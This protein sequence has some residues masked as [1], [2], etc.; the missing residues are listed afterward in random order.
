MKQGKTTEIPGIYSTDAPKTWIVRARGPLKTE[1]RK[2]VHGTMGDAVKALEQMR[3]ELAEPQ[4]AIVMLTPLTLGDCAPRWFK[5]LQARRR[6]IKPAFFDTRT[7]HLERF[8]LPYFGAM[9]VESIKARHV[10][11]W[12]DWLLQQRQPETVGGRTHHDAGKEY[13]HSTLLCVWGLFQTLLKFA[14]MQA[15]VPNPALGLRFDVSGGRATRPKATLTL[16]EIGQLL[17]ALGTQTPDLKVMVMVGLA[18][19]TRFAEFSAMHWADIDMVAGT[20]RLERSQIGG[21]IGRPKTEATRRLVYLP[22]DVVEALRVHKAWQQE[23]GRIDG[24]LVFPGTRG[25]YRSPAVLRKPLA[26]A[27]R[28][29]GISK[30]ITAHCLRK[31]NNNLLRQSASDVVVR[32]MVGHAATADDMTFLYSEVSATEHRSAQ[33]KAFGEVFAGTKQRA[34]DEVPALN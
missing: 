19:G 25:G 1:K 15:D 8:V 6:D 21:V 34:P 16:N 5:V 31:S 22:A 28:I 3:A 29:A 17:H 14:C 20:W 30:K 23:T 18:T 9:A 24:D 10:D 32:A 4:K 26:E 7:Y 13:A 12:K 2:V 33:T 11:A 27:C